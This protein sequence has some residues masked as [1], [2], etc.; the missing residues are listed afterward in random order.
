MFKI[1]TFIH[2]IR[3][4][5]QDDCLSSRIIIPPTKVCGYSF[6]KEV[7]RIVTVSE[8]QEAVKGSNYE[9]AGTDQSFDTT[10]A[11]HFLIIHISTPSL[12]TWLF[13][14]KFRHFF[15]MSSLYSSDTEQTLST[16][17]TT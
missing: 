15:P 2:K 1:A 11:I 8:V 16:D 3:R 5:E 14:A 4:T 12:R 10:R 7:P 17:I 13:S 6:I 9:P